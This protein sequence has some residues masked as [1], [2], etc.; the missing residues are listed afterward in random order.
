MRYIRPVLASYPV[1]G[2]G[3]AEEGAYVSLSMGRG[4]SQGGADGGHLQDYGSVARGGRSSCQGWSR[5]WA[6]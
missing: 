6:G 3:G 1:G 2:E 4:L 5:S